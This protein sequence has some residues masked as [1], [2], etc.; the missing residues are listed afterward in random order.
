MFGS[1]DSFTQIPIEGITEQSH[2]PTIITNDLKYTVLDV[3]KSNFGV[4]GEKPLEGGIF[5]ITKLEIENTG[6]SEVTV[7]GASWF[8]KD[9]DGRIFKPKTFDATPEEDERYF[10][11]QIPPGF[12]IMRDVGFEVPATPEL[13][14]QLYVADK[15]LAA[16]P[17]L[18]GKII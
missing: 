3:R 1:D 10:S 8:V 5:I 12:K 4:K 18:L 16:E 9:S 15:P 2:Q 7:Y 13:G 11:I 17:I 6:K 14:L